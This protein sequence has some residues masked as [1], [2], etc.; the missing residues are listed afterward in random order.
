MMLGQN[1]TEEYVQNMKLYI[2]AISVDGHTADAF[3]YTNM[4]ALI[5]S[6]S[7]AGAFSDARNDIIQS[8]HSSNLT[9]PYLKA[10]ISAAIM[11]GN[12]KNVQRKCEINIDKLKLKRGKKPDERKGEMNYY[13]DTIKWVSENRPDCQDNAVKL[14]NLESETGQ[15]IQFL[16]AAAYE[17]GKERGMRDY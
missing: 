2:I 6:S 13:D 11:L 12:G 14:L 8:I 10:G 9:A 7:R 5:V 4:P 16:A 1:K 17:A 15:A 3:S